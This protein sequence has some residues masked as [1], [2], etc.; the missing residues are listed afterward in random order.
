MNELKLVRAVMANDVDSLQQ[1]VL[2]MKDAGSVNI[3]NVRN[4]RGQSL[5]DIARARGKQECVDF[6]Q[7]AEGRETA[8]LKQTELQSK[9][10]LIRPQPPA[11]AP[12]RTKP[13][14]RSPRAWHCC[15]MRPSAV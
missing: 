6:L 12:G 11:A 5:L 2:R 8:D 9:E 4:S 7:A 3:L 15:R 10:G 13:K 14:C 1:A